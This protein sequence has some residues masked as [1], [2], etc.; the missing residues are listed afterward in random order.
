MG[1]DSVDSSSY[2]KLAADGRKWSDREFRLQDPSTPELLQLAIG[3]LATASGR[4]LP[5]PTWFRNSSEPF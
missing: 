4:H 2:V 5:L 3:N 1:V